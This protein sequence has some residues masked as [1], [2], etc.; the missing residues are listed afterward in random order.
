M[1]VYDRFTSNAINVPDLDRPAPVGEVFDRYVAYSTERRALRDAPDGDVVTRRREALGLLV[2]DTRAE[3]ATVL[4]DHL[5]GWQA[6]LTDRADRTRTEFDTA[7]TTL[8]ATR[9]EVWAAASVLAW[10]DRPDP[11]NYSAPRVPALDI[12]KWPDLVAELRTETGGATQVDEPLRRDAT[13][14]AQS[15]RYSTATFPDLDRPK[16][17]EGTY[18]AHRDALARHDQLG[19]QRRELAATRK[20]AEQADRRAFADHIAAGKDGDPGTP[21]ANTLDASLGELDLQR[22]QAQIEVKETYRDVMAMLGE[23][24]VEWRNAVVTRRTAAAAAY[25]TAIDQVTTARQALHTVD[26]TT[27]WLDAYANGDR[28]TKVLARQPAIAGH[29]WTDVQRSLIRDADAF[30]GDAA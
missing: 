12:A 28:P 1:T 3:L 5:A 20:D 8:V 14:G 16:A 30:G 24:R 11:V 6:T 17:I 23:H 4:D 18:A 9:A 21:N 26:A 29:Q 19:R 15:L 13:I 25:R 27:K 10:L 22:A 2:T 7:V